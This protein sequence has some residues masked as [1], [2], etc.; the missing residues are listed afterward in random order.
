VASK[1]TVDFDWG[2]LMV[3]AF[4]PGTDHS[5]LSEDQRMFL[6]ALVDNEGLWDPKNG[7]RLKWFDA[8]DLPLDRLACAAIADIRR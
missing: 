6:R 5:T 3:A 2:P 7:N 8:T 4:P 1:Y